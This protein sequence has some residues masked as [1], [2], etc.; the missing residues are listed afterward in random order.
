MA[1]ERLTRFLAWRTSD[2]QDSVRASMAAFDDMRTYL[3]IRRGE[4]RQDLWICAAGAEERDGIRWR[5]YEVCGRDE[6]AFRACWIGCR[7]LTGMSLTLIRCTSYCRAQACDRQGRSGEPDEGLALQVME[8]AEQACEEYKGLYKEY[9]N[10]SVE[11]LNYLLVIALEE[12]L[13]QSFK[14]ISA[15]G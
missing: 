9:G 3:G 7:A 10:K 12:R 1:A 6:S 5:M 4:R 14:S 11:M 2:S 13:N 15:A 8:Q